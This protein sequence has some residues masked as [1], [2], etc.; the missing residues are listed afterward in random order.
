MLNKSVIWESIPNYIKELVR[1]EHG[2]K[3]HLPLNING[4]PV[5]EVGGAE[6]G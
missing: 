4:V 3:N 1:K 5:V 2:G 6:G